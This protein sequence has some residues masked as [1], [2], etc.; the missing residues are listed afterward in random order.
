MDGC[1]LV[2][3]HFDFWNHLH[4]IASGKLD[5]LAH[6]LLC[7]V[8]R[9]LQRHIV[10]AGS[11]GANLRQSRICLDF[12]APSLVVHEVQVQGVEFVAGHL[13]DKRAQFG[14]GDED[15]RGVYHQ[16][17]QLGSRRILNMECGQGGSERIG[18]GRCQHLF[19]R[20]QSPEDGGRRDASN[21]D[22]IRCDLKRIGFGACTD[23]R[24]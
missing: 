7:V 2:A 19:E 1:H 15:S 9:N 11:F 3:G 24:V 10:H 22:A 17:A 23:G 21:D 4:M 8:T 20:H 5:K 12:Y 18:A 14:Q 16:F 6:F 13:Y